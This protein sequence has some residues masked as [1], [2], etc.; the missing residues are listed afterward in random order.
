TL[1]PTVSLGNSILIYPAI[2][3]RLFQTV[4]DHDR[5][6]QVPQLAAAMP[7]LSKDGL[8]YTVQLRKGVLFNDGTP[9]NAAAVVA[10]VQRFMTHPESSRADDYAEVDSVTAKGDYTVVYHLKSRDSAFITNNMYVLSPTA[11][12]EE[13]DSFGA[14]PVCAGPF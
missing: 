10:T 5:A 3:Q 8:S 4:L 13:G 12:A 7:T 2:C 14:H 11:V 9:F 1:D 6:V